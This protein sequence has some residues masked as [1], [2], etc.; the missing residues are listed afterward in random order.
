MKVYGHPLSSCTRKV[1]VTLAEKGVRPDFH[2]V[3][4]FTGEHKGPE[5]LAR[6]PFGVV[7]AIDDDG[8]VLYESRAIIRYLDAR[9]PAPRLTPPS[10]RDAACM[11]QWLSVDQSYIA[12]HTR[13][14]AVE[15][16]VKKHEGRA[17][18][19][20]AEAAA[21]KALGAALAIVDRALAQT[22]GAYL[23]GDSFTLADVSLMPY[24]ASLPMIGAAHLLAGLDGLN[25]WW[26]RM[27]ERPSWKRAVAD[28]RS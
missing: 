17:A 5:H 1:L 4:L 9:F 16:I 19:P 23:V 18:D 6:Q 22:R 7:P 21:E 27:N 15:R 2:V 24:V 26:S 11:D 28:S 10:P 13:A 3:N 20:A 14:L 25:A 12:P 8:F